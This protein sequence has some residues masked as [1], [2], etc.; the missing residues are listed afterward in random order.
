MTYDRLPANDPRTVARD[1]PGIS[2]LIFPQLTAGLVAYLNKNI[3]ACSGVEPISQEVIELSKLKRSMLFEIAYAR[4]EQI[5]RG[6]EN[7]NWHECLD[8]ASR[9]QHRHFDASIPTSLVASDKLVAEKVGGNLASMLRQ[10]EPR[11]PTSKMVESPKV[12][13]YQW[14]GTGVGDFSI[15]STLIEVK[16]T[17]KNFGAGDYRQVLMYWLLSYASAVEHGSAEWTKCVL[18]NPRL[19]KY[20]NCFFSELVKITAGGMSK[21]EI[22]E[23]FS[24]IIGKDTLRRV[25]ELV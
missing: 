22:L 20:V 12:S 24:N 2:D 15:G 10:L 23:L 25:S 4:G 3:G 11:Y 19:N 1:I 6:E 17:N 16:C 13:G 5:L 9:R 18:L 7:A 14:I 21:V 8:V